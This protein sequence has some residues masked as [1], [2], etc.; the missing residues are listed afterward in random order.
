MRIRKNTDMPEEDVLLI[1]QASD[2]LA[3]PVRVE[4][5]RYIYMENM[6]RRTVCNKDIVNAFD[7]SQATISQHISKL[8]ISK[9]VEVQ[10]KDNFSFYYVN[11]G[12][13]GKYLNAVK[14]LNEK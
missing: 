9:L 8:V 3:H 1:A 6:N 10:K 4:I 2:A 7:Y 13:L 14:K 5:F 12:I 11:I